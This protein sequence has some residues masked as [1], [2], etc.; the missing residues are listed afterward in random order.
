MVLDGHLIRLEVPSSFD[1]LDLVQLLSDR[2]SLLAGLDEDA[3]HW[4]SVAVRE[5]V[6]N[7]I[8]HGNREDYSKHVTVEFR[9]TPSA[10]I[11]IRPSDVERGYFAPEWN[12]HD[13]FRQRGELG[14]GAALAWLR[15][16]F[17]YGMPVGIEVDNG[18]EIIVPLDAVGRFRY[19]VP[20]ETPLPPGAHFVTVHAHNE[21]GNSGPYSRNIR[22]EALAGEEPEP[23]ASGTFAAPE[24]DYTYLLMPVRLP[25]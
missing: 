16:E 10:E 18:P 5:S 20:A 23:D 3:I 17:L 8:K 19:Q 7:A 13:I 15:A 12:S 21:E 2:L 25:G 4:V 24:S 9:L 14:L 6:I 22:F 11:W 1:V